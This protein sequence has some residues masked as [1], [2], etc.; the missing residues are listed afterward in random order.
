MDPILKLTG[1]VAKFPAP[2]SPE[3]VLADYG[4]PTDAC[5]D[6]LIAELSE[7]P[8]RDLLISYFKRGKMLRSRLLFAATVAV[9]GCPTTVTSAA[10]AVELLHG[11]SLIHDD[12]V[13]QAA[14]RRGLPAVHAVVSSETAIILGD[15]LVF[16]SFTKLC[17]NQGVHQ[18]RNIIEAVRV[19]SRYAEQCCQGQVD[20]QTRSSA[21]CSEEEYLTLAR[22]KT[23]SQFA[24]AAQLG[25]ILVGASKEE[26][27]VLGA[28]G[29]ALGTH[30]RFRTMRSISWATPISSASQSATPLRLSARIS[31]LSIFGN[32][33][34]K[35]RELC[36]ARWSGLA[37][38]FRSLYNSS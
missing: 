15:Y 25:A 2:H 16:R 20:E 18:E 35:Q 34:P 7:A 14:E 10:A 3:D 32:T 30:F 36:I 12:I 33:A 27:D 19:L 6:E 37:R 23:A 26:V 8:C 21:T 9:G 24:A 5:R 31:P 1:T 38:Q 28:Y 17:E 13:D 29:L 22:K 11:A 4:E